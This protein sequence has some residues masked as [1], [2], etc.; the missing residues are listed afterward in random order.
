MAFRYIVPGD[1]ASE[2]LLDVNPT[3]FFLPFW[4]HTS[5]PSTNAW[6]P[7]ANHRTVYVIH[8]LFNV[9]LTPILHGALLPD[10]DISAVQ[11]HRFKD[12]PSGCGEQTVHIWTVAI[13]HTTRTVD[14][15]TFARLPDVLNPRH[16]VCKGRVE[17]PMSTMIIREIQE[18]RT[19]NEGDHYCGISTKCSGDGWQEVV[20]WTNLVHV[21]VTVGQWT[22]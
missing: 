9:W 17:S 8:F 12:G 18:L 7:D 1:P 3:T 21:T 20:N 11:S 22:P 15:S 5:Q 2:D 4:K 19:P 13:T 10:R 14:L 6:S 16:Y